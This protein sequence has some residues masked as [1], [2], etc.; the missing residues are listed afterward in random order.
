MN[1]IRAKRR[2]KESIGLI[3]D[4]TSYQ[5]HQHRQFSTFGFYAGKTAA[6]TLTSACC[7]G[8]P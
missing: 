5:T 6:C 1:Q 2:S 7:S 8:S 4:G 3:C